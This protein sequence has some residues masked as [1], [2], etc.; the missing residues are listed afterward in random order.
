MINGVMKKYAKKIV[1]PVITSLLLS[2]GFVRAA[3]SLN[4]A[5]SFEPVGSI[6]D[7]D[8]TRQ[9]VVRFCEQYDGR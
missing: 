5:V 8:V 3:E 6:V 2:S 7:V 9:G 4:A 1:L